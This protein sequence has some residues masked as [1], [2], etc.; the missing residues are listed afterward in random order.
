M[1]KTF[2]TLLLGLVNYTSAQIVDVN[3]SGSGTTSFSAWSNVNSFNY[4]GYGSFPGNQP[5]PAPIPATQGSTSSAL[6]RIIGS[7]TGGGPFLAAE[8]IY[9]GSFAQ[10]PNAL[11]GTLRL[12]NS[13]SLTNLKTLVFQIQIG[14]AMG[15]DFFNPS[16]VPKLTF[17]NNSY[18]SAV[19]TNLVN[20]YQNGVFPSPETG[21]DEPV[22]VNTWAYQWNITND[23]NI[24]NYAVDFSGVTH[25]QVYA[26][27]WDSTSILQ[28]A[29][30]IP[31]PSTLSL[32]L[33]VVVGF[34]I[35]IFKMRSRQGVKSEVS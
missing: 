13:L 32:L 2:I 30:V 4:P 10:V 24:T 35:N 12:S 31:E 20:R 8:S 17:N 25:S 14:E 23:L 27:R 34:T 15:Y 16:G 33:L 1:K 5:W 18:I 11:G 9:F 28:N 22:Y 7:P 21:K 3:F 19:F 6:N 29:P 26:M